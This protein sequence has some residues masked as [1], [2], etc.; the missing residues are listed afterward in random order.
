MEARQTITPP[1]TP[2]ITADVTSTKAHGAVMATSPAR[3]PLTDMA[4]SGFLLGPNSHMNSI[5]VPPP[6]APAIKVLT[7]ANTARLRNAPVNPNAEPAL[8]PNQPKNKMMVPSTPIGMLWPGIAFADP[9]LLY[10]PMRAPN[11]IA[12]ANATAPPTV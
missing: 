10:R 3:M 5:A 9:S 8:K 6:A 1:T 4:P 7:A 11:T 12:P 2:M